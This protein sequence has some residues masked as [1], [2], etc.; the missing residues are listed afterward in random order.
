MRRASCVVLI[1]AAIIYWQILQIDGVLQ[2]WDP[3]AEGVDPA[4]LTPISPIDWDNVVLYGEY[5][6]DR[7]LV[8]HPHRVTPFPGEHSTILRGM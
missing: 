7:R 4:L 6:L 5:H 8:H 3:A 1:L 2:H